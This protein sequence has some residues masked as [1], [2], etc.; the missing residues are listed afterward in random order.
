[1]TAWSEFSQQPVKRGSHV[2]AARRGILR[3]A[4]IPCLLLLLPRAGAAT[5]KPFAQAAAQARPAKA[6]ASDAVANGYDLLARHDVA[7]AE[8]AFR[9]AIEA[10]PESEPA[11]RG[12]G[13]A[14]RE[15]G[16]WADAL[17]E[18]RSAAVQRRLRLKR[19]RTSAKAGA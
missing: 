17:R 3:L 19:G 12:L 15:E 18:L 13:L 14:L 11:H 6:A 10:V 9:Q 7:G 16:K 8:A 5:P 2:L 4:L 1:M